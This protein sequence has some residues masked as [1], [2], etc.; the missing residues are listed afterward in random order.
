MALQRTLENLLKL[1]GCCRT[2]HSI[3]IVEVPLNKTRMND[4]SLLFKLYFYIQKI[5]EPLFTSATIGPVSKYVS[6]CPVS[7]S[8]VV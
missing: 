5:Q 6:V 1:K 3:L 8:L 2:V 7:S 4:G